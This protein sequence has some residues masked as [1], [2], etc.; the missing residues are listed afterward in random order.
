VARLFEGASEAKQF[1]HALS[2]RHVFDDASPVEVDQ[3]AALMSDQQVPDLQV[4]VNR[5]GIV[6]AA[7][8]LRNGDAHGGDLR[9]SWILGQPCESVARIVALDRCES[10]MPE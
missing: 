7:G 5:T 3:S 2:R 8:Q 4:A 6:K 9:G 10:G 1:P